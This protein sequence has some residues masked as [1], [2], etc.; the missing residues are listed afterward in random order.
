[1]G[2]V[3]LIDFGAARYAIGAKSKNLS[4]VLKPGYAPWEQ[5][6][7]RGDQ[8]AWTD[9]YAVGATIYRAVTG[10]TPPQAPDRIDRDE[11]EAPSRLGVAIPAEA[12]RALLESLAVKMQD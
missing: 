4:V 11:L 1:G 6:Q 8:G 7:S 3:K 12:E 10:I 9:V 2:Q 5:Y